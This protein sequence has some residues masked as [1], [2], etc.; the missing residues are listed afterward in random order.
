MKVVEVSEGAYFVPTDWAQT[1]EDRDELSYSNQ[2][3]V[4]PERLDV[5]AADDSEQSAEEELPEG[6]W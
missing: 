5:D 2:I 6:R 4:E 3:L 1:I